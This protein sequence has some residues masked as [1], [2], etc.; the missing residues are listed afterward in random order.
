VQGEI[1]RWLD[2]WREGDHHALEQLVPLLY[3]ELRQLAHS[4]MRRERRDHTLSTTGL[5][6][7][8]YLRLLDQR[9]VSVANRRQ[10]LAAASHTMRRLLVDYARARMRDKRG[11]GASPLPFDEAVHLLSEV[12]AEEVLAVDLALERLAAANPRGCE[13]VRHRLLA[14]LSLAETAEV[15]GVSVK[16]VQRDWLAARAWLR[17]ELQPSEP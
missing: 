6:H 11:G 4:A 14:G 17:K 3:Q 7:E 16:T 12:E 5:V 15:L 9:Q 2:R 1:T 8:V 13:V 10:F